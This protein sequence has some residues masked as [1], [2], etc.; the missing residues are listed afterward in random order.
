MSVSE[1]PPAMKPYYE[2]GRVPCGCVFCSFARVWP[3]QSGAWLVV[4]CAEIQVGAKW[5]ARAVLA[6]EPRV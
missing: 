4:W 2:P 6:E 5:Y 1:R 3:Q